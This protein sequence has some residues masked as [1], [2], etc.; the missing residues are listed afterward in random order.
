MLFS[1]YYQ[2]IL[3]HGGTNMRQESKEQLL[4]QLLKNSF[5]VLW[6]SSNFR[7]ATT[8]VICDFD[9]FTKDLDSNKRDFSLSIGH[10]SPADSLGIEQKLVDTAGSEYYIVIATL[11]WDENNCSSI[12]EEVDDRLKKALRKHE[13]EVLQAM[14]RAKQIQTE[15][16][17]KE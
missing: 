14:E 10:Y 11:T 7:I 5:Q 6:Q 12:K 2:K 17:K 1:L 15:L 16:N 8:S 9:Q 13:K 3:K 4:K